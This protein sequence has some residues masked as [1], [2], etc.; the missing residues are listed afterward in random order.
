MLR[1]HT[2]G[3]TKSI[4]AA[5]FVQAATLGEGVR[6]FLFNAFL[7]VARHE[8]PPL[9]TPDR[10]SPTPETASGCLPSTGGD[11]LSDTPGRGG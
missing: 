6:D 8:S 1:L 5:T 2:S 9:A 3:T 11:T 7:H 4:W 10:E